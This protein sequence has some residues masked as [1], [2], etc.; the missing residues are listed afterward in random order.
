MSKP[1]SMTLALIAGAG[2]LVVVP[3]PP[4]IAAT[5]QEARIAVLEGD[6]LFVKEGGLDAEWERQESGVKKFQLDGDRIAVLKNDGSLLAKEGDL[7]PDWYTV[8]ADSVTDFQIRDGR[9]AFTEGNTLYAVDGELNGE[10]VPQA[11]NVAKFQIEGDRIGIITTGHVLQVKEGDLG[12]DWAEI[13]AN[14]VTDFQLE[15][16]RIAY[17]EGT[18]LWAQEGELDAQ[19]VLQESDVKK[20]ALS[21]DRIGTLQNNGLLQVKGGDLE[22]GWA[23]IAGGV[24]DFKLDGDRIGYL[25]GTDLWAQEGELDAESFRQ[26]EGVSAFDLVGDRVA[27]IKNGE[28]LAKEGDLEPGWFTVD[29]D[30]ATAV[31]LLAA[32]HH[33]G[34]GGG[35]LV[36]LDDLTA[37]YGFLGDEDVIAEGLDSLNQAMTEGEITNTARIAAFLATLR[38]ESGFR[39]NAGEAG[40]TVP[41]LGRGYIQLTGSANYGA[42]G[43]Y[44]G[45][46]LLADPEA[47]ASLQYSAQIAKW[48][49]TIARSDTNNAADNLNMGLVDAY[50][51]YATDAREDGERC[52]D[53]Q[54]ALRYFNGGE[55]PDGHI[56]C[57]RP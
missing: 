8:D 10:I 33:S 14:N 25:E 52:S 39:Y 21:G 48:Y 18:E 24:T 6:T 17:T 19:S 27:V 46:D 23:E 49:W 32:P 26:E 43:G 40:Q 9:I 4:A 28:L 51:G 3:A 15:D 22:P 55:L 7:G 12:P 31:Q 11:D 13:S 38:N 44:V 37:I 5:G 35:T 30:S 45:H 53:F 1:L 20:F 57:V 29:E 50:I 34:G 36:T 16:D 2:L 42:A 41:Y 56:N 54:A 47:A